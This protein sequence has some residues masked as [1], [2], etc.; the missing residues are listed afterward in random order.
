MGIVDTI[1]NRFGFVSEKQFNQKLEE[2]VK[3]GI[4]KVTQE[5][6]GK[7]TAMK[8]EFDN[9]L[10]KW[11]GETADAAKW[12]MP[13]PSIFA[14]QADMYR[15][16][17]ILGTA[18]DFLGKDIGTSKMNVKRMVGEETR[19]IPNHDF[20]VLLRNPNP[21]D[22]GIEFLQ[23]TASNYQLNGN[24]IWWLNR[25][26]Q[27][28]VPVEIWPIPFSMITPVPDG[29]SYVDHYDYFPGNGKT[30]MRLETHEIV[31][32]KTY[33]PNSRFIGL[34]PLESLAVTL[35][36]DLA[37]RRTN[38]TNYAEYGGAPQ[39]ILAF[40]EFVPEP[41]WG[42][43]KAEKRLAAKRN[44]MMMLRGVGEGVSWLQR[45][46]S[47]KDMDFVAGL[48]Q[49]LTDTFNRMCPGLISVLSENATEANALAGRATY[50]EY[51][52]WPLQEAIAQKCTSDIMPAYGRKLLC[53][54]DDPRVV[55]KKLKLEEQTAYER[56]H[57]TEEVRKEYYQDEPIGDER[58]KL[59]PAQITA[60]AGKAEPQPQPNN[61]QVPTS[62]LENQQGTNTANDNATTPMKADLMRW[63][64]RSLRTFGKAGFLDP[65]DSENIPAGVSRT[66]R[67]KLS[68][69][70]S[71]VEV[72]D[73]FESVKPIPVAA[74]ADAV[75][76]LKGIELGVLALEKVK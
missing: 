41:A 44:E 32:F 27:D 18:V 54:F 49:N 7:L 48:K 19:D 2:E 52:K 22:S 50:S 63:K 38:T 45:A 14:T 40:K 46:L 33:N 72:A 29:Q 67:A 34:S 24:A 65:F 61:Q 35:Q 74:K 55:D 57:T 1:I 5:F 26:T 75:S 62:P 56:T 43:I 58:D 4:D 66:I 11:L 20:E 9:N 12:M 73:L 37:M 51:T 39:S 13:D 15:V 28:D 71:S 53:V 8:A 3:V 6:E 60:A 64:R 31:H 69:C 17:P 36:G 21:A 23:Y 76:V 30:P 47:N 25:E 10:P 59:L 70:K 42:D 16:S 68:L